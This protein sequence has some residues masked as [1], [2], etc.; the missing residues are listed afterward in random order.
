VSTPAQQTFVT[1]AEYLALERQSDVKLEWFDGRVYAMA[2]GTPEHSALAAQV[3]HLLANALEGRPCRVFN[4]DLKLRV[5]A[6]GL[7][8]YPDVAVLCGEV[9]YDPEN[10]NAVTNPVV[11]VEVLSHTTESYDRNEKWAHYRRIP[12]LKEYVL[13]SQAEPRIEVYTRRAAD[14]WQLAEY[15]AG[16]VAHLESLDTGLPVERVYHNPLAPPQA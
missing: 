3:A 7:A 5:L 12:S 10:P 16:T 1:Y 9:A 14:R 6:T 4:S 13:V 15:R 8:T 2:G 11:L